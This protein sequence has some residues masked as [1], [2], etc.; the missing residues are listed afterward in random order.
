MRCGFVFFRGTLFRFRNL[1]ILFTVYHL[2][3]FNLQASWTPTLSTTEV[4]ALDDVRLQRYDCE[5]L[6]TCYPAVLAKQVSGN[7]FFSATMFAYLPSSDPNCL[8]EGFF[9]LGNDGGN[10]GTALCITCP[11]GAWCPGGGK[12]YN[13]EGFW[14]SSA[15]AIPQECPIKSR[16][17]G[18]V[19][20]I[21]VEQADGTES[22]ILVSRPPE[23]GLQVSGDLNE[24]TQL[25]AVGYDGNL[26]NECAETY[27]L[28]ID[29]CRSCGL[30]AEAA[31]FVN[32]VIFFAAALF[33]AMAFMVA[34]F[35]STRMSSVVGNVIVL[36]QVVT[37]VQQ[38]SRELPESDLVNIIK[39][40]TVVNFEISTVKPGCSIPALS[41]LTLFWMTLAVVAISGLMF[42]A[43]AYLYMRLQRR[44]AA[45]DRR[46]LAR[47]GV[48]AGDYA[49]ATEYMAKKRAV[50]A[51]GF[52]AK[53]A[54]RERMRK[55]NEMDMATY[56][57]MNRKRT[58]DER[59]HALKTAQ[60]LSYGLQPNFMQHMPPPPP[61]PPPLP[62]RPLPPTLPDASDSADA[63]VAPTPV[64]AAA[65][66]P[67][68]TSVARTQT[69]SHR[70]STSPIIVRDWSDMEAKWENQK[71]DE[72]QS[73][74]SLTETS[75]TPS[76]TVN[77]V[78]RKESASPQLPPLPS[79]VLLPVNQQSL[80]F[81]DARAAA[82]ELD[83]SRY[84]EP[85]AHL[86]VVS[87]NSG[88]SSSDPDDT[89]TLRFASHLVFQARFSHS[90]LILC[91]FVYLKLST[92]TLEVMVRLQNAHSLFVRFFSYKCAFNSHAFSTLSLVLFREE[93]C[94]G[95]ES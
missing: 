89:P 62:P 81:R 45:R 46:T 6:S 25:C 29:I 36:Q 42:L 37:V 59:R 76:E 57:E 84:R 15:Y 74:T 19:D 18:S 1:L 86:Y 23:Q 77:S 75:A 33:F 56:I 92:R 53:T 67:L 31:A 32:I 48:S 58:S 17:P 73:L 69:H 51:G 2:S 72:K 14:S 11:V 83:D 47:A 88:S 50:G 61:P 82:F 12:A 7:Y 13:R 93:W 65:D 35:R 22:N 28:D 41:Q 44:H 55:G 90:L 8:K 9:L 20:V 87:K 39:F 79:S 3:H 5:R 34:T 91:S 60:S 66:S 10:N 21:V 95:D 78:A 49:A 4:L 27:Y 94:V 38:A 26:C 54:E 85:Y 63:V 64:M 71:T 16:C 43:A 30:D 70:L 52:A 40:A 24:L 68:P 80:E